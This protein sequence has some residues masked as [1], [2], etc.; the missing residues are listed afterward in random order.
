MNKTISSVCLRYFGALLVS[1]VIS[2]TGLPAWSNTSEARTAQADRI[3]NKIL[4]L[5]ETEQRWIQIDLS[6]QRLIAWEGTKPVYAIV[7]STGK[8]ETPTLLGTF[9]IQTKHRVARMTGPGYDV[10]D[11]PYTMYFHRGYAIHGAYWHNRFGTPVSHGC[12]NVAPNHAAWLFNWAS[13]GTP[14]IV[15]D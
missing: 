15:H 14:V 11:V 6:N 8:T 10:P 1:A 13:V 4:E 7:I 12:I 3:A 5:Q 9:A 2:C